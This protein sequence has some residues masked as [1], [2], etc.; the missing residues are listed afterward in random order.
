MAI[1]EPEIINQDIRSDHSESTNFSNSKETY[2]GTV[3]V[4]ASYDM[5]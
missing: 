5:G 1:I 4:A 2:Y 3:R